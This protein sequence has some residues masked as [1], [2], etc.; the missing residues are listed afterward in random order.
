MSQE[1][2]DIAALDRLAKTD[3]VL[4]YVTYLI[5]D[6]LHLLILEYDLKPEGNEWY[7]LL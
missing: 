3:D 2:V 5:I 1:C 4:R 6:R 7:V